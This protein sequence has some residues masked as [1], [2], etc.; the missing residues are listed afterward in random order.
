MSS[1]Q[2]NKTQINKNDKLEIKVAME[3]YSQQ[4]KSILHEGGSVGKKSNLKEI[5]SYLSGSMGKG[6]RPLLLITASSD[7]NGL[8]PED[9]VKAA[10]A[11]ELLHMATLVHDDVMDDAPT[12]RGI[13]AVHKKF[14]TKSAVIC[15]DYLLSISLSILAEMD[16]TRAENH[17]YYSQF[18]PLAPHF[19]RVLSDI[20]KGEYSQ[21]INTGNLDV[22]VLDYLRIISGKTAALFYIAAYAGGILGQESSNNSK[23]LGRFGWLLG[24]AF[25]IADDCKDYEWTED[26][27]L[28]PVAND[29]KNGVIT[30]PL[31]LAMQK[32]PLLRSAAKEIMANQGDLDAFIKAV[33]ASVGSKTA[34]DLAQRYVLR[35]SQSLRNIAPLKREALLSI[36][37]QVKV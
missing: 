1:N 26:M 15:G 34:K 21:H 5:T 3:L 9:S 7:N 27:A 32:D 35:A 28:K 23:D 33:R 25:Q 13:P 6:A 19:S 2:C 14:D 24:M 30:L 10:V 11:I 36:L 4:I 31:I 8:V 22:N 17:E 29:I 18:M 12:R 16:S 37:S 20:C